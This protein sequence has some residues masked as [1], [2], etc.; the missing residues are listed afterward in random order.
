MFYTIKYTITYVNNKILDF[1]DGS[2]TEVPSTIPCARYGFP[3]QTCLE[4]VPAPYMLKIS[5]VAFE[6]VICIVGATK[7]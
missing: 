2:P 3:L 6:K 5:F 7:D 4:N 1:G